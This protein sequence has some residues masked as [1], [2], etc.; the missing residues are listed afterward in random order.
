M[1]VKHSF[2]VKGKKQYMDPETNFG[3]K[4]DENGDPKWLRSE[5]LHSLYCSPNIV[6]TIKSIR[7]RWE[8]RVV[9]TEK[10]RSAFKI[11]TEPT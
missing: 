10:G 4:R 2:Y 6:K 3:P 11:L 1:H 7:L 5:K 8:G 9:R